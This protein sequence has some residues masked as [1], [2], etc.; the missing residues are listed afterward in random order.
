MQLQGQPQPV[1]M[2][3]P[4]PVPL[5]P[6]Q[7]TYGSRLKE[8]KTLGIVGLVMMLLGPIFFIPGWGPYGIVAAISL[9]FIGFFCAVSGYV[10]YKD[11]RKKLGIPRIH[12]LWGACAMAMGVASVLSGQAPY[13]PIILGIIAFLVGKKAY[14][15]GDLEGGEIGIYCGICAIVEGIFLLFLFGI[16]GK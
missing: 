12:N 5:P 15:T 4:M 13:V 11:E 7:E 3:P 10:G 6:Q 14:A 1:T 2:G 16:W 9:L 8:Y